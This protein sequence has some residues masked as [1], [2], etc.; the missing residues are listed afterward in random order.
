MESEMTFIRAHE[1]WDLMK[2]RRNRKAL[3]C[4][5]VF[6]L[7]QVS[8]SSGLKY[9][10]RIVTKGYRQE[11]GVDFDKVFS[12]VVKMTTLRFLLGVV[13]FEDLELL[14]LD[15]KTT[16]LHDDLDEEIYME[17]PQGSRHQA[18]NISYV[19]YGRACTD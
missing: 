12:P 1:T 2:L 5:W 13:T 4:K 15:V 10:A 8:D 3:L 17:Q 7:K 9:K 6:Q 14:Q 19:G 18:V 11:Y 16:F